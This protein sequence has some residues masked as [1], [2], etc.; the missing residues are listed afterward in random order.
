LTVK[1]CPAIVIVPERGAEPEFAPT[2]YVAVP[3]PEPM[4]DVMV[5]QLALLVEVHWQPTGAVTATFPV[6]PPTG[7]D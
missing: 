3:L 2:E 4:P 1:V 6:P 7:K 5:N